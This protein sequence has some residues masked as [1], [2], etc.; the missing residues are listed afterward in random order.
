MVDL[1]DFTFRENLDYKKSYMCVAF[2]G[3]LG[4]LHFLEKKWKIK[5]MCYVSFN[6]W[7]GW[8][9]FLRKSGA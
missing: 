6:G 4:W 1:V 5:N 2:S 9:H 7:L 8:L 3:W